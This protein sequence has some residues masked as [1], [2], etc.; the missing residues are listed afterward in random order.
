M[1]FI[2]GC[3][4]S[5]INLDNAEKTNVSFKSSAFNCCPISRH[6]RLLSVNSLRRSKPSRNSCTERKRWRM[7]FN[8]VNMSNSCKLNTRRCSHRNSNNW[9]NRSNST[10]APIFD[11]KVHNWA[12][13]WWVWTIAIESSH[14]TSCDFSNAS[15]S[16]W[17][18]KRTVPLKPI[19]SSWRTYEWS[20]RVSATITVWPSK[21]NRDCFRWVDQRCSAIRIAHCLWSGNCPCLGIRPCLCQSS[22]RTHQIDTKSLES[23]IQR[24]WDR[25]WMPGHRWWMG[26]VY[27]WF[28]RSE[29]GARATRSS[30]QRSRSRCE[31]I[32]STIERTR[33]S[34]SKHHRQSIDTGIETRKAGTTPSEIVV[35]SS[36]IILRIFS[37][38]WFKLSMR[39]LTV[40]KIWNNSK[41]NSPSLHWFNTTT[42]ASRND[43][44]YSSMLRMPWYKSPKQS[45][46]TNN[47]RR[48]SNAWITGWPMSK[49]D[50]RN[51]PAPMEENQ[52]MLSKNTMKVSRSEPM[53]FLDLSHFVLFRISFV[54][55]L[56][57]KVFSPIW[58]IVSNKC[59][60]PLRS[61]VGHKWNTFS[62]NVKHDGRTTIWNRSNWNRCY[63]AWKWIDWNSM[64]HWTRSPIGSL[65]TERKW[66]S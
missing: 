62:P 24:Q 6:W 30:I 48:W 28:R 27:Q 65:I 58:M 7:S 23:R 9:T 22:H 43:N 35:R 64:R 51:T 31:P 52:T 13:H 44:S 10:P 42:N 56:M 17:R 55:M 57:E 19:G 15:M 29:T 26:G 41:R 47:S 37:R 50:W 3:K 32:L 46:I 2:N 63:T 21:A 66:T 53:T 40:D 20:W 45:N 14:K 38:L 1:M 12:P 39:T 33:N 59:S 8:S 25:W 18:S 54:K 4:I 16:V 34:V 49:V 5:T 36:S 60:R 11:R 61:K